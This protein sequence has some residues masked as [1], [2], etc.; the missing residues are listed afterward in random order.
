[1]DAVYDPIDTVRW[2]VADTGAELVR[3]TYVDANGKSRRKAKDRRALELARYETLCEVLWNV[4]GRPVPFEE[5]IAAEQV[6]A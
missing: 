4:A 1:M 6:A 5:V 2:M 3:E